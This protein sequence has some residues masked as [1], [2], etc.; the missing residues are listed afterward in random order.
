MPPVASSRSTAR[1]ASPSP[2]VSQAP[3]CP[4]FDEGTAPDWDE[5]TVP[6][7]W[8]LEGFGTPIYVNIQYPFSP[9]HPPVVPTEGNPVGT[10]QRTFQVPERWDGQR[11]ILRFGGVSSAFYV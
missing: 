4:P 8:E 10:Y 7:N 6:A 9:V 11:M 2:E 5:I 1:G 3:L